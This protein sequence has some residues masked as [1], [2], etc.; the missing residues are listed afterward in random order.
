M[1]QVPEVMDYR[2][3]EYD[4]T[5]QIDTTDASA[6]PLPRCFTTSAICGALAILKNAMVPNTR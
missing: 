6:A 3:A 5:N 1:K 4:V 2:R